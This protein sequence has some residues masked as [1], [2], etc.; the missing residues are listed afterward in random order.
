M[1]GDVAGPR[2]Q[3]FGPL[4]GDVRIRV[5][6]HPS[7]DL[8]LLVVSHH[9]DVP[10]KLQATT[11]RPPTPSGQDLACVDRVHRA[12][13]EP[14]ADPCA[15]LENTGQSEQRSPRRGTEV[16]HEG[17]RLVDGGPDELVGHPVG[18]HTARTRA[19]NTGRYC[20]DVLARAPRLRWS[21]VTVIRPRQVWTARVRP[22]TP[23]LDRAQRSLPHGPPGDAFPRQKRTR[24][25]PRQYPNQH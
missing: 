20:P 11:E 23:S 5:V 9:H 4:V 15:V 18:G 25:D 2:L 17:I 8:G 12:E 19:A 7:A 14:M 24:H 6:A 3:P 13:R 16:A 21:A 1:R 22:R 10:Q